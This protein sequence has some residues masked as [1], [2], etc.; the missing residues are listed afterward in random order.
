MFGTLK[1]NSQRKIFFDLNKKTTL[2]IEKRFSFFNHKPFLSLNISFSKSIDLVGMS[3]RSCY[4][5]TRTPLGHHPDFAKTWSGHSR[6]LAKTWS[7]H[8][9]NTFGTQPG[10][11]QATAQ[12]SLGPNRGLTKN[13]SIPSWDLVGTH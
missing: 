4:D 12:T 10:P 3:P 7:C 13:S 6:K 2:N 8:C 5:F 9:R 11:H 1:N